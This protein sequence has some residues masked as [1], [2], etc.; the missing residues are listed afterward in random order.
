[1]KKIFIIPYSQ[2]YFGV[3]MLALSEDGDC[4][5]EHLSS[6]TTWGKHDMG[7][8]SNWKHDS[9]D[10]EY[11]AGNWELIYVDEEV[12]ESDDF[13]LAVQRNHEK[14]EEYKEDYED[15]EYSD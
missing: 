6:N 4:I 7:I 11:G 15:D 9:Y 2:S 14:N 13:K 10:K 1:M 8:G 5:T 3:H 12:E